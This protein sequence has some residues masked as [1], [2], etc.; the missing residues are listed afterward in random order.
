MDMAANIEIIDPYEAVMAVCRKVDETRSQDELI[1]RLIPLVSEAI[2]GH[3]AAFTAL[4]ED[5][6]AMPRILHGDD[7]F[8]AAVDK[9]VAEEEVL[10]RL[11]GV[12]SSGSNMAQDGFIVLLFRHP[13][14]FTLLL[15]V[16]LAHALEPECSRLLPFF[17]DRVNGTL[18]AHH[19]AKLS[20]RTTR[21]TVVALASLAEHKDRDTGEH[22][23]RVARMA[24]EM[25]HVLEEMGAYPDRITPE[26][27]RFIGTA[28][29]LHDVGKVAIPDGIL[30]KA[31]ALEPHEWDAIRT[32][33]VHGKKVLDKANLVLESGN[34]LIEL[35]GEVA[36]SHH[37]HFNGQGY[38]MGLVGH[39]I[40]L[41]SRI[42]ALVD[43]FDALTSRRPYKPAWPE[44]QAVDYIRQRAGEQFDP[45][46]VEA[47]L[48]VME[49]RRETLVAN[50]TERLSV[51]VDVLDDDHRILIGLI[52]Q[53]AMS[54]RI[55]NRRIVES[56]LDELVNYTIEHFRREEALM[57]ER[58]YAGLTAHQRQ[59]AVFAETVNDI[60]WQYLH[61]LRPNINQKVLNF[62]MKWL[63]AHIYREDRSVFVPTAKGE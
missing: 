46:L 50:W 8:A 23:L 44:E 16:E 28:S 26:F 42:V 55:G 14:Q 6:L 7:R 38:P 36:L 18:A 47:F 4:S 57:A 54:E 53:L 29:I 31:G 10:Q 5:G 3:K 39:H 22:I 24:D 30:Q 32:H 58:G 13:A 9:P 1:E 37:E 11:A 15:Y 27:K 20:E 43:V 12:L 62:L 51:E 63:S 19:Y 56:V 21:A 60:R 33:T 34:Y 35:A 2:G 41:A 17:N 40:P 48:K 61:G 45:V 49:Y 25:V 52:N 59:H